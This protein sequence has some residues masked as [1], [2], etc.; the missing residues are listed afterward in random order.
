MPLSSFQYLTFDHTHRHTHRLH[1]THPSSHSTNHVF[2]STTSLYSM[3]LNN[4][5]SLL[6][7][8]VLCVYDSD[9]SYVMHTLLS[10]QLSVI[11]KLTNCVCPAILAQQLAI[12]TTVSNT[13]NS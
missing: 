6:C 8:Y 5:P 4:L 10:S 12:H 3:T 11:T 9:M 7:V 13:H 1:N 2:T